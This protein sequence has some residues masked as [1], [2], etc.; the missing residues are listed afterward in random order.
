MWGEY[1]NGLIDEVRVYN[2]ALGPA[3]INRDMNTP[4]SGP[5]DTTAPTVSVTNP[6]NN[7]V[8]SGTVNLSANA[9]DNVGVA[10]VQFLL[11]GANL[12]A[13]DTTSPYSVSWDTTTVANGPYVI[14]ARARDAAGNVT[15]STQVNVTVTNVD[16]TPPTVTARTPAP[17]ATNV[18]LN[19]TATATFSEPVQSGTISFVLRD[20][21]GTAV[22]ANVTYNSGTRTATLTPSSLLAPG[23]TYTA[24]VSGAADLAGNVMTAPSVWS[25]T[26]GTP[27]TT[28]PSITAQTPA[29]GAVNIATNTTVTAQFSESIQSG[30]LSFVLRDSSNN[31]VP[32]AVAYNDATRTATLTP[33]ALLASSATY[34]ATV[35]GAQDAAGNPMSAPVSWSFTTASVGS[36]PFSIWSASAVPQVAMDPDLSATELGVKFRSDIAGLITGIRFY[37]GSQNTGTHVGHLWTSTGTLLATATFTNE[38]ATGWQQVSF[39]TP[40][41]INPNTTYIASYYAPNGRYAEDD[42]YFANVGVDNGPLHALQAGVDGFNGVYAYGPVGS[43]PNQNWLSAN[44]WVDVVMNSAAD[45]TPPSVT[46][47]TPVAGA[48]NVPANTTV[49]ATFSESIQAASLTFTL[50]DAA[51]NTVAANVTYS[52]ATHTATLTPTAALNPGTTY[53]ATVSGAKDAANNVMPSPVTW[54]FTTVVPDTTPPTVTGQT[55]ANGATNVSIGTTVTVTFSESVQSATISLVLKDA[56]NNTVA[57]TLAYNDTTRTATFTP[58][59]ALSP[60]TTYTATVSGAKDQAGNTMTAPV[61][62]S[63]TTVVADTTPP[64]VTTRTPAAGATNVSLTTTVT[65]TFS[66]AVQSGT[67]TFTL[68]DPSNNTVA[69]SLT[70][71]AG[72]QTATLT[73]S[74]ALANGTTY[75]ASVTGAKDLSGN[76]MSPV[77]WTFTTVPDTTP[78]TVTAQSPAPNATNVPVNTTI[79]ATFSEAIQ[80]GTPS[81]VVTDPSNNVI[82]GAVSYNGGTQTATFTP[83]SALSAGTKF[84]VTLSGARDLSGNLMSP[85]TWSFTTTLPFAAGPFSV[86]STTTIPA[87]LADTD[88]GAVE[89]GMKFR[90]DLDGVITGV[91]FYKSSTNTGVHVGNLWSGSGALLGTVTF[92]GESASGWQQATFSS[93]IAITAN[94]TYVISYHTNVGHYSTTNAFFTSGGIDNGPLHALASGVDGLNG[95]Y[96]YGSTSAFPASSFQDTNYFVDVVFARNAFAQTTTAQF[97]AGTGSNTQVTTTGDGEIQLAAGFRDD[98]NGTALNTANWTTTSWAGAG[99]GPLSVTVS[100]GILNI[101]GAEILSTQTVPPLTPVEGRV[102]IAAATNRNFGL[103]TDLTTAAGNYWAVFTTG[104]TTNSLYARVNNNGTIT[105][106]RIS[107][108]PSGYH[109][110]RVTPIATGFQFYVDGALKTTIS[111]TF[112][113]GTPLRM[114]MSAFTGSPDPQMRVDYI[115]QV[116]NATNGTYTS[117][118]LDAGQVASWGNAN[119]MATLPA[120]TSVL[121]EVRGGN[122][123]T[124]DGSWSGWSSVTNGNAIGLAPS[125]YLQYRITFTT[126]DPTQTP[127]IY[128]L[129]F[130]WS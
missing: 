37:K 117:S 67:I 83:T 110:Y 95:V 111:Q 90:S 43:F 50:K 32:S 128:D 46:T 40:V 126:T 70:Y 60:S 71:N 103:A 8:V 79:S 7:A 104:T 13:E 31:V 20:P 69:A 86:F 81:F 56:A 88:T 26:T 130:T 101:R 97:N 62:W 102:T 35:S 127:V 123:A 120:G 27:D 85:V 33:N 76:T 74:A 29:P 5:A 82:A 23:T 21:G 41:S 42:N 125:R 89:L 14:T 129:E 24:T 109:V 100:G 38:T 116:S 98:F 119:W 118:V 78:P 108:L 55:P 39:A 25:F 106:V 58:T 57:G 92:S 99:G 112:P 28:P 16:S 4:A 122:T 75:T 36:G 11:N 93:P 3:D 19:T 47:K 54:S 64:T 17:N 68:K 61:S 80:S 15:T 12:G 87:T 96:T 22:P 114:V 34:T 51:N 6:A 115:N 124:P 9:S 18:P 73:P 63:F 94:T 10:G 2:V 44:Y 53:T 30:T 121:V 48:T 84:T 1:F 91:R 66:E 113:A 72:T 49:A 59:S 45:T 65:A 77:T 52:D 107:A 105:D